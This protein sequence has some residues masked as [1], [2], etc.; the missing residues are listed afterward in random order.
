MGNAPRAVRITEL[1]RQGRTLGI[2][3]RAN[4]VSKASP[5]R[6]YRLIDAVSGTTLSAQVALGDVESELSSFAIKRANARGVIARERCARCGRPRVATFR[7]C[8]SCGED[9]EPYKRDV[10]PTPSSDTSSNEV[11][12][13][14][15]WCGQDQFLVFRGAGL[16]RTHEGVYVCS[17]CAQRLG[18]VERAAATVRPKA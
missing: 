17:R 11:F 3:I 16:I 5:E 13:F 15:Q 14:C 12:R 7:W 18:V 9:F 6:T 1:R 4:R 10:R 8:T 2:A